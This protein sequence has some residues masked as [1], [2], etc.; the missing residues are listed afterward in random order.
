MTPE[1]KNRLPLTETLEKLDAL[2]KS[3]GLSNKDFVLVDEF[4]YVLQGYEISGPEVESGHIDVYTNPDSL[5][6][7]VKKERSIIPPKDS[8]FMND[9]TMF[10]QETGYGLD[11]LRADPEI[12]NIHT[13]DFR[14]PNGK[15]IELMRAFE[16]TNAFVRQTLMHYSLEDVGKEKISE[17][18]SKLDLIRKAAIK[19][20]DTKLAGF[21][22]EKIKECGEK[23]NNE[24]KD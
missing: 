7:L 21:C 12:F 18:L 23:W 4:A 10:M 1:Q 9:W 8:E 2:F 5:P 19:K 15:F 14:L 6:W 17:W 16:M 22:V 11:M 3:W 13:I 20:G 24:I